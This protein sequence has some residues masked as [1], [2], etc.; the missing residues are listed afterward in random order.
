MGLDRQE[1][2]LAPAVSR[3]VQ[4]LELLGDARGVPQSLAELSRTLGAAKSSVSNVCSVLEDARLIHRNEA[5]Y[6]LGRRTVEFG[7]AYLSTFDQV[8]EFYRI[9]ADSEILRNELVQ[10]AV[11]EGTDA[12]YLARHEGRAPLR[13]TASIGDKLPAS[14]AAVGV[15]L[16]AQLPPERVDALYTDVELPRLTE[17]STSTLPALHEKLE[18]TRERGYSID[19]GEVF[20]NAIG[21]A[22]TVPGLHIDTTPFAVCVSTFEGFGAPDLPEQQVQAIVAALR[23]AAQ[24]LAN[25]MAPGAL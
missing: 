11:L 18:A 20:P 5:G 12:L 3:A 6:L 9:V 13:L 16:L 8:R 2:S 23:E 1:T 22:L 25:P 19:R 7:G 15:A 24:G 10:I 14:L 4:V 17:R 21:I